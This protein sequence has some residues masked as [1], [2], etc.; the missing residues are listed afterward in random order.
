M[1]KI[2]VITFIAMFGGS[3]LI[4][5]AADSA[6][7]RNGY[8]RYPAVH[9]NTVV[10]VSEGDLWSVDIQGGA[11]RRLTTHHG[12]E[13]HPAVSPDGATLAFSAQYEGPTEVYTMP[14]A[15]GLPVRHTFGGQSSTVVGWTPDGK[16]LYATQ[17]YSTLPN[18][19]LVILN[20]KTNAET[21]VP[22]DQAA[23]GSFETPEGPL[24][25]TRL[26]FQG[27]YTKR[28][29]GGTVQNLWK[30]DAGNEAVPLT[31]DYPGTSKNPMVWNG[32]IYFATDR[33]GIMNLWSM[34]R[35]GENP[36]QLTF[37][38][39]FDVSSPSL[40]DGRIV[41][42][43]VSDLHVYD[44]SSRTD[45][46]IEV[47][48]PSD[49]DQMRER[50]VANPLDYLTSARLSPTGDRVALVSRG[51]VFTA[52]V[53]DGR[54]VRVTR[55]DGIRARSARFFP[56]G[57]TLIVLSDQSG[58][59]EFHRAPADGVG[60][61]EQLTSGAE[62]LRFDGLPS[63]DGRRLAFAD[64]DQ[65]LWVFDIAS[66]R[67]DKAAFSPNGM[68]RDLVWSPDSRWLAFVRSAGNQYSQ[69]MLLQIE[70]GEITELTNDRV[71]SY[72]PAWPPATRSSFS[73]TG[74]AGPPDRPSSRP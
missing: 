29:Q 40:H 9:K 38:K 45:R 56:D 42:Q 6:G 16:I 44:I 51:H 13:S 33:D 48:L 66:K 31:S 18:T 54:F 47:V 37:H 26:P 61:T 27:S 11:A 49:F 65:Q 59:W 30:F 62:V 58:E 71:D 41:Y 60:Q 69:I 5:A 55:S 63:P 64:K 4:P 14:L 28:Y 10:F 25:F 52:P 34:D 32:R 3:L 20:P 36:E 1:K 8:Y 57:K 73:S 72:S 17:R 35:G 53:G 43:L 46:E 74:R 24:Y 50:W 70:T 2:L 15:G 12:L 7:G 67:L 39:E 21:I 19:R 22:L 23:D 68:F